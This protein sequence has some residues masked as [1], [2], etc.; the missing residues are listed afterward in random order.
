MPA[1]P[2]AKGSPSPSPAAAAAANVRV[3]AADAF[4]PSSD[5]RPMAENMWQSRAILHSAGDLE[6]AHP[7]ALVAA[8]ILV[9][10]EE[11]NRFAAGCID[12]NN[13]LIFN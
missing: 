2:F 10:P 9:Y 5:G 11:G 8:D 1:P 3:V 13:R 7:E 12:M 4:Y 6:A